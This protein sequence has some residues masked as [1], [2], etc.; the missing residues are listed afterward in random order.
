MKTKLL[1]FL[2][3]AA[4]AH[5]FNYIGNVGLAAPYASSDA[6]NLIGNV[7]LSSTGTYSAAGWNIV[8]NLQLAVPGDYTLLATSGGINLTGRV[9]SPNGPSTLHVSYR[10]GLNLVVGTVATNV[11]IVDDTQQPL[12]LPPQ[13]FV[14][15]VGENLVLTIAPAGS[16]S[17]YLWRRNGVA[18]PGATGTSLALTNL[19]PADA[20]IYTVDLTGGVVFTRVAAVVAIRSAA[21]V[22]GTAVEVASDVHHPNGNVYDQV[23]LTG[24]AATI[25]ADPGQ[26]T[27][28]SFLDLNGDLV[29]VELSGAGSLTVV[30][31][32]AS[33]PMLPANY[34][35]PTLY[36]KGHA[37]I[38]LADAGADTNVA[39]FS[40][41]KTNAVN[42]AL[43]KDDVTYDGIADIAALAIVSATGKMAGLFLGNAH[44]FAS[45]GVTGIYAAGVEVTGP[46]RLGDVSAFGQASPVLI[47]GSVSDVSITGGDLRQDNNVTVEVRGVAQ[48]HLTAGTKS[49]GWPLSPLVNQARIMCFGVD[50]TSWIIVP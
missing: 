15:A 18:L 14:V 44:V 19:Q 17:G 4:P 8:G 36:M 42:Q 46:V 40:V 33:G 47:F 12:E 35:Q 22:T 31:S 3:C 30:L 29:Q 11:V 25:T 20:G 38:V 2:V 39:V 48:I 1:L 27:R 45:S 16:S 26:I 6:A 10:R 43:F 21:K 24:A 9:T 32:D 34:N 23:L 37:T 7:T 5:A 28:L 50:I 49:N 41:G 13:N